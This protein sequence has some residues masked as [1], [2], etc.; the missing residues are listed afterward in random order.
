MSS[1]LL[2]Y[3][4]GINLSNNKTQG[5]KFLSF[6]SKSSEQLFFSL[7]DIINIKSVH[8]VIFLKYVVFPVPGMLEIMLIGLSISLKSHLS[9]SGLGM[10]FSTRYY[11]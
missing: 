2:L 9:M 7:H 3:A 8:E 1:T 6:D 10:A 11:F 4:V 5:L